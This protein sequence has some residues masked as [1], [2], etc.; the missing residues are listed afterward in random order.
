MTGNRTLPNHPS[1]EKQ[2]MSNQK[3]IL[4]VA[5]NPSNETQLRLAEEA[6]DIEEGLR[7]AEYRD[8]F[9]LEQQWATRVRD[10]QRAMQRYKPSIVHFCGHGSGEQGIVL[11]NNQGTTQL[12]STE[13]LANFFELF[14]DEVECVVLNACLSDVQAKEIVKHI[15]YV[16][17]MAKSVGDKAA[18]AFAVGF[19]DALAAGKDYDKAFR[20]GRSAIEMAGLSGASIPQLFKKNVNVT[21]SFTSK[22][23]LQDNQMTDSH[24]IKVFFSYSHEDEALRDKLAK[25]LKLLERQ[26]VIDSWHDRKIEAGA[27]WSQAIDD[28]LKAADIILLLI[29]VNSLSSD[30]CYDIEITRAMQQHEEKSAVV[31]PISLQPCDTTG[32][33]FMKIQG[34]P[35]NFKPVTT[36]ENQE[37]AFTDIAKG[38]RA[39]AERI[40]NPK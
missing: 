24:P 3:T 39:V 36:W 5:A 34:F 23:V 25:H 7:L 20:F 16:I 1:K 33:E 31:I 27:E 30:Y 26:K 10:L 29:S 4:F 14:V 13:A 12:V 22:I 9:L 18:I 6:R 2:L 19:Y 11:E 35:K 38:I 21:S 28:N 32:A 37:E 40:R 8:Q 15:P 17:G